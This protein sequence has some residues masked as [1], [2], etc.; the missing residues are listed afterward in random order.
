MRFRPAKFNAFLRGNA[1]RDVFWRRATACPCVAPYSGAAKDTCPQCSGIG[2][3]WAE[4]V[5]AWCG[6]QGMSPSRASA[7]FG[8]WEP[9]DALLTIPSDSPLYGAGRNDRIRSVD[10]TS[11]FSEVITPEMNP[12][13]KGSIVSIERVFWLVDGE[14]VDGGIPG[15]DSVGV[16]SWPDDDGPPEDTSFT[17]EGRRHQEVFVFRDLPSTRDIGVAGLPRK[18]PVRNFDIFGRASGV[19][20]S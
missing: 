9:G 17:V 8:V 5:A 12:R 7:M 10:A 14:P 1:R 15:V 3:T 11:P 4:P 6:M 2:W 13:L 18:L 20:Q 16:M 19:E